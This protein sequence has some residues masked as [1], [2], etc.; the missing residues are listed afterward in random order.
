MKG[1]GPSGIITVFS[2]GMAA[3]FLGSCLSHEVES[4]WPCFHLVTLLAQPTPDWARSRHPT[5]PVPMGFSLSY[6][7]V[8]KAEKHRAWKVVIVTQAN[9]SVLDRKAA[10][11]SCWNMSNSFPFLSQIFLILWH[12]PVTLQRGG[13]KGGRDSAKRDSDA[14]WGEEWTSLPGVKDIRRRARSGSQLIFFSWASAL[15]L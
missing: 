13:M 10:N 5:P 15:S 1:S 12:R 8:I 3:S 6:N 14:F 2:P 7:S 4:N 9:G 11:S